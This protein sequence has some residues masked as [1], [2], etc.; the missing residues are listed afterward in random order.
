ML[1]PSCREFR[2]AF[3]AGSADPHPA[4]CARCRFWAQ[5]VARLRSAGAAFPLPAALEARLQEIPLNRQGSAGGTR[6]SAP[7]LRLPHLPQLPLPDAVRARLRGIR[8]GAE[9]GRPRWIPGV[10]EGLAASCLLAF[11]FVP[12]LG[13]PA[14]LR[15]RASVLL[16]AG[17]SATLEEAGEGG[18]RA[19]EE[20]GD[21]VF[22]SCEIAD[23]GMGN[24]LAR[25][26]SPGAERT[27]Q[28]PRGKPAR[29]TAPDQ[30]KENA[31]GNRTPH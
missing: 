8:S 11:F 10:R 22:R 20:A 29:G 31:D 19:L 26:R 21:F 25:L 6:S 24:L 16:T 5:G 27:V 17:L 13:D 9:G 30:G 28:Q 1:S 3:V 7:P 18:I 23:R 14:R 12:L 4:S 2:E 15:E